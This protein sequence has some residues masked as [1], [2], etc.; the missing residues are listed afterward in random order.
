[1]I[2]QYLTRFAFLIG[3]AMASAISLAATGSPAPTQVIVGPSGHHLAKAELSRSGDGLVLWKAAEGF[4]SVLDSYAQFE[5]AQRHALSDYLAKGFLRSGDRILLQGVTPEGRDLRLMDMSGEALQEVWSTEQLLKSGVDRDE[6]TI[7]RD[8]EWWYAPT[9]FPTSVFIQAGRIGEPASFRWTV[10]VD[11]PDSFMAGLGDM[12]LSDG[13]L[14]LAY[15]NRGEGWLLHPGEA[16]RPLERPPGCGEIHSVDGAADGFWARCDRGMVALYPATPPESGPVEPQASDRITGLRFLPDGQAVAVT[17]QREAP[18][19]L[20]RLS[21][22]EGR[23]Q[24]GPGTPYPVPL[25]QV[26]NLAGEVCLLEIDH[27][28]SGTPPRYRVF[29]LPS[30]FTEDND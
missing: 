1:M 13:T 29:S 24:R 27:G 20:A 9:Y 18:G 16:P 28:S 23:I 17:Q 19:R 30:H 21:V 5:V 2:D 14:A 8:L 11:S 3:L 4:G 6:L 22:K 26:G 12:T 10:D 15:S 25:G 7:S